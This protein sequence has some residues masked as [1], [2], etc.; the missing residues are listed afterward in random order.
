MNLADCRV[1]VFD[2]VMLGLRE[3]LYSLAL[4]AQGDEKRVLRSRDAMHPPEADGPAQGASDG[5]PERE[6]SAQGS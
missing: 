6:L 3:P 5:N 2:Q 1:D 4:F